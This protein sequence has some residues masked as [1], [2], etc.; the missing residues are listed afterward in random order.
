[1]I[2]ICGAVVL[3]GGAFVLGNGTPAAGAV[4]HTCSAPDKQ[5]L[6][7]V[8]MNMTQLGFWSDQL[9]SGDT[10]AGVVVKQAFSEAD[11]IGATRPTD[12][13]LFRA[14]GMLRVM[15]GEY[16]RAIRAKTRGGDAGRHMGLSW[17]LAYHVHDL[18]ADAQP[19]LSQLGCDPA[20]LFK[21]A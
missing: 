18:L 1:M 9:A 13:T 16:G 11:Q 14:R 2:A 21:T 15:F 12:P 17:R 10:P 19:Q 8:S 4:R 20:P 7:T 3:L 5:F 6:Q